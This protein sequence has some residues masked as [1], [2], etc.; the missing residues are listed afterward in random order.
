VTTPASPVVTAPDFSFLGGTASEPQS[1]TLYTT[2]PAIPERIETVYATIVFESNATIQDTFSLQLISQAGVVLYEQPTPTLK[3]VDGAV[4][5]AF[6]TW[7]RLGNDTA[8][9]PAFAQ[10]FANDDIRRTWCNMR[11]PDLVL[12]PNSKV[13]LLCWVDDGGEGG[14]IPVSNVAVTTTRDAGAVSSTSQ[15]DINA[16]LVPTTSG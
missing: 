16:L 11:L 5:T 4:L 9:L 8:Q 15:V 2:N 1:V 7:S 10:L 13:Q 6:L 3:A 14:P 12:G